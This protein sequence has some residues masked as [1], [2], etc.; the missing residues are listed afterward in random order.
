MV[1]T[2]RE[3][4]GGGNVNIPELAVLWGST[5]AFTLTVRRNAVGRLRTGSEGSRHVLKGVKSMNFCI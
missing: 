5:L 2:F 4:N 1:D 3:F